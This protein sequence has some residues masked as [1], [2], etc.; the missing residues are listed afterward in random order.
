MREIKKGL[1]MDPRVWLLGISESSVYFQ[2]DHSQE[3]GTEVEDEVDTGQLL[4][5]LD[6]CTEDGL[7]QVGSRVPQSTSET[8]G[9]RREVTILGNELSLVFVV[10]DNLGEFL[11]DVVGVGGLTSDPGEGGSSFVD[12]A[13]L[14]EPSRRLG[15]EEE[16]S[17]EDQTGCQLEARE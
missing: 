5:H 12:S 1:L 10:G 3:R 8:S 17:S 13:L 11:G 15:E 7:S 2:A 6:R 9:P 14:D 4:H 16:S